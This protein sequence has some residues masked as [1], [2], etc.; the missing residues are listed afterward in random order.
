MR[1]D[2][3][4]V[5]TDTFRQQNIILL[6]CRSE[7]ANHRR[8]ED[9]ML[10]CLQRKAKRYCLY[11]PKKKPGVGMM[12][13]CPNS[14]VWGLPPSFTSRFWKAAL[15]P[16]PTSGFLHHSRETDRPRASQNHL[17]SFWSNK[18]IEGGETHSSSLRTEQDTIG[19]SL[20][21]RSSPVYWRTL[22]T[23]LALLRQG[24]ANSFC[25]QSTSPALLWDLLSSIT[26]GKRRY[27]GVTRSYRKCA[28]QLEEK[29]RSP[30][31][32][33][34][35]TFSFLPQQ[36]LLCQL[37]H[38]PNRRLFVHRNLFIYLF[39]TFWLCGFQKAVLKLFR[40]RE[41]QLWIIFFL[42]QS[43]VL[44]NSC[45]IYLAD[46][47]QHF[48]AVLLTKRSLIHLFY[49]CTAMPHLAEVF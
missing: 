10:D 19:P 2:F 4:V 46:V 24:A 27:G 1:Q 5:S 40:K 42:P 21:L 16:S 32:W 8:Y 3:T 14:V 20:W 29:H 13:Q 30:D 47:G 37:F 9:T 35:Q 36:R 33:D 31:Y 7:E 39:F 23:S 15:T 18:G 11:E 26:N 12:Q 38:F 17:P 25:K 6:K 44:I 45:W 41:S 34:Q 28:A 48:S 43:S 49:L 22:Q